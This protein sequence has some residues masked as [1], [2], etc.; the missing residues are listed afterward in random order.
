[1]TESVPLFRN[2][3]YLTFHTC[4]LTA[5]AR[6][7][8]HSP[9]LPRTRHVPEKQ[10]GREADGALRRARALA[11]DGPAL[12]HGHRHSVCPRASHLA[13]SLASAPSSFKWASNHITENGCED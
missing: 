9:S 8:T 1:M 12:K 13:S 5:A 10:P 7:S 6:Q 11:L 2:L 4:T 3:A